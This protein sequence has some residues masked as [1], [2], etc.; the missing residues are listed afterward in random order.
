[1]K[2][3]SVGAVLTEKLAPSA[4]RAEVA[5]NVEPALET[6]SIWFQAKALIGSSLKLQPLKPTVPK[7]ASGKM[8][9]RPRAPRR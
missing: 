3:E 7:L 9:G 1:M 8:P 5:A 2:P 6:M 4:P